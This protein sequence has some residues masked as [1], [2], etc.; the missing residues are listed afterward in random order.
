M[1]A[2]SI[3]KGFGTKAAL[4][5]AVFD[6]TIAGDDEAIPVAERPHAQ[7]VRTEPDVRNKIARYVEGLAQRQ[8]RTAKVQIAIRDGRHVDQ[9]LEPIWATLDSEGLSGMT[10][11]GR[12][13]LATGH[14]RPGIELDEVRDRVELSAID[15]YERLVLRRGWDLDRYTRWLTR[16]ITRRTVPRRLIGASDRSMTPAIR[17][18]CTTQARVEALWRFSAA[19]WGKLGSCKCPYLR[20]SLP[21]VVAGRTAAGAGRCGRPS[22]LATRRAALGSSR[23]M[24]VGRAESQPWPNA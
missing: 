18:P 4:A 23:W 6:V 5:K 2:E 16:A 7:A 17:L 11:L 14:L 21:P 19:A 22:R 3:Y 24:G 8:H 15:H 20:K 10:V 12:H 13:L 9:S 1:S